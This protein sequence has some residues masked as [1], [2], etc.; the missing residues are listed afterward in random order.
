MGVRVAVGSTNPVKVRGVQLVFSR[1]YDASVFPVSVDNGVGPQPVGLAVLRGAFNRAINALKSVQGA[2]FSVG[3]ESGPV[4]FYG[5]VMLETQV[6]LILDRKGRASIGISASFP[7][8][9]EIL[10]RV[11]M[12][13]E[14]S[15]AFSSIRPGDLGESIGVIGYATQGLI[16]RLDLT[17]QAVASALLPFIHGWRT[18]NTGN[19]AKMLELRRDNRP[20]NK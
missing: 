14:L 18:L 3:I 20:G 11:V 1:Y 10:E 16:T 13:E 6:A 7:L 17:I 12:G 4:D 15:R 9:P 5:R 2:D 19:L 8:P